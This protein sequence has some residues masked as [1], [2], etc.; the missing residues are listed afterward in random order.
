MN[1]MMGKV[2]TTQQDRMLD[3]WKVLMSRRFPLSAK[4]SSLVEIV[5][6]RDMIRSRTRCY[7]LVSDHS[8]EQFEALKNSEQRQVSLLMPT[9][10]NYLR[11]LFGWMVDE[12]RGVSRDDLK[13]IWTDL[14]EEAYRRC[15]SFRED[16]V[17]ADDLK[18]R[19]QTWPPVGTV[20]MMRSVVRGH[21][22]RGEIF[23]APPG[24]RVMGGRAIVITSP[25]DGFGTAGSCSV[26]ASI[27]RGEPCKTGWDCWYTSPR[28]VGAGTLSQDAQKALKGIREV[29]RTGGF[30]YTQGGDIF[31]GPIKGEPGSLDNV[32]KLTDYQTLSDQ[33]PVKKSE[34]GTESESEKENEREDDAMIPDE[35]DLIPDDDEQT[36]T[37]DSEQT[38]QSLASLIDHPQIE[39]GW[40][41]MHGSTMMGWGK[42]IQE[43][44]AQTDDSDIDARVVFGDCVAVKATRT[45]KLEKVITYRSGET[46]L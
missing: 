38:D 8:R 39:N 20:V 14:T 18:F 5:G 32:F 19:S 16:R 4:N 25:G 37:A 36:D 29:K 28:H 11:R 35:T 23:S 7:E 2:M 46:D 44:M 43:A 33:L 41:I 22:V 1:K 17:M 15:A 6:R 40:A 13:S 21:I 45:T 10:A 12:I 34:M 26:T 24:V 31:A 3:T 30:L 9:E 42:T 27:A